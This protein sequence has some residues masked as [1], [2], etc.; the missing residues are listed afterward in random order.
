M[1][2][3]DD[4]PSVDDPMQTCNIDG[5]SSDSDHEA[6][7]T[8]TSTT[9]NDHP[10]GNGEAPRS[11]RL[12]HA[13]I[14]RLDSSIHDHWEPTS[15]STKQVQPQATTVKRK[16]GRPRKNAAATTTTTS[17]SSSTAS[18]Y[19]TRR[20]LRKQ[21]SSDA[22]DD[23]LAAFGYRRSGRSRKAPTRFGSGLA[24]EEEDD[25][26]E[27]GRDDK[28]RDAHYLTG[29]SEQ[30]NDDDDDDDDDD[31]HD[32]D[33]DDDDDDQ[34]NLVESDQEP[35]RSAFKITDTAPTRASTRIRARKVVVSESESDGEEKEV[36]DAPL[37]EAMQNAVINFKP[38][39]Q[40]A[41]SDAAQQRVTRTRAAQAHD[42]RTL[43]NGNDDDNDDNDD[44]ND[45]QSS[46]EQSDDSESDESFSPT[47]DH[48]RK[49]RTRQSP[50]MQR[51][52][53]RAKWQ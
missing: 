26:E 20:R 2:C 17:S 12:R 24:S 40:I 45:E 48:S 10:I 37:S 28:Q 49:K 38:L 21:A 13:R 44:D 33:D 29:D 52:S 53:K 3:K 35:Y 34:F 47:N 51:S 41:T 39:Q 9:S 6:T 5:V 25:S 14:S 43:S 23:S 8:T 11:D 30:D 27:D 4:I 15:T 42:N 22:G 36:W 16:R 46:L 1:R 18:P 31:E 32:D 50:D 7:T 19:K